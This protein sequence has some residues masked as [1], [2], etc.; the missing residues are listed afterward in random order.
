MLFV[1][2]AFTADL[3]Q[4]KYTM[5]WTKTNDKR[6]FPILRT[7]FNGHTRKL[8]LGCMRERKIRVHY[9]GKF[10]KE[11]EGAGEGEEEEE[12]GC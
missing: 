2:L 10:Y 9:A 6:R 4:P 1:Q 7:L 8:P 5:H 11:G 12:R 3:L